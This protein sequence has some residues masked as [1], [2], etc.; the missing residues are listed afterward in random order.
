MD[1]SDEPPN[2]QRVK[3][4]SFI[5]FWI[6]HPTAADYLNE[7]C[8]DDAVRREVERLLD[9]YDSGYLEQ[10]AIERVASVVDNHLDVGQ[11]VGH[12]KIVKRIAGGGMGEFILPKI[13]Q[14]RSPSRSQDRLPR[15]CRG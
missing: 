9:S 8:S 11:E 5:P 13:Y 6:S 15:L 7:N 12:Y 1:K 3:S 10:P 2:Y 4:R 14:P